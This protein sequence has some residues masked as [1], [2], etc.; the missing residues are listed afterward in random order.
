[1]FGG[2]SLH[3]Q[4]RLPE[5]LPAYGEGHRGHRRVSG[6]HC[7]QRRQRQ[8]RGRTHIRVYYSECVLPSLA[9]PAVLRPL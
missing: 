9:L 5:D 7:D 8:A 1:M 2:S 6:S 3:R 4:R